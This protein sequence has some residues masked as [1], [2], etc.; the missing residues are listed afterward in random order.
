MR[1][2]QQRNTRIKRLRSNKP[3][4]TWKIVC[5]SMIAYSPIRTFTRWFALPRQLE[6]RTW[7]HLNIYKRW[8]I[9][10]RFFQNTTISSDNL[11]LAIPWYSTSGKNLYCA[12][13]WNSYWLYK[14][15]EDDKCGWLHLCQQAFIRHTLLQSK[16]GIRLLPEDPI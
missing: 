16:F 7:L 3:E 4:N 6:Q 8:N 1:K 5:N 9:Y 15:Y 11:I 13:T 14:V 12:L 10:F 2:D